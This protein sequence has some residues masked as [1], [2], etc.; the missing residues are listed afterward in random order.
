[1]VNRPVSKAMLKRMFLKVLWEITCSGNRDF[2]GIVHAVDGILSSTL[3][4]YY[5]LKKPKHILYTD[6]YLLEQERVDAAEGV[7]ELQR[8]GF[9]K[10]DP[11]QSSPQFKLLTDRGKLQ[12]EK[13]L[14]E[15]VLETID[16]NRLISHPELVAAV[17]NDYGC[18]D[19]E[20]A[21]FKAL[22]QVE[23][24]VRGKASLPATLSGQDLMSAAF[25][26]SNGKLKNPNGQTPGEHDAFHLLF[27]G[28]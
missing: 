5:K 28:A 1:M 14:T 16:I 3:P 7:E 9:I 27:H 15:M 6:Y 26:P 20:S 25:S 10:N 19:Y 8:D 22:R 18:Q 2:H 17:W 21:V 4:N 13:A 23:I 24:A 11:G 12:A